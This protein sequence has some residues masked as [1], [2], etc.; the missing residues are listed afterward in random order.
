MSKFGEA[1]KKHDESYQIPKRGRPRLEL[2]LDEIKELHNQGLTYR[3]IADEFN[4]RG[5]KV[6]KSTIGNKINSEGK[7]EIR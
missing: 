4:Q 2:P 1:S 7:Y 6:S 3:E 5:Y